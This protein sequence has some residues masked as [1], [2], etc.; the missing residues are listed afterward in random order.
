[1][2]KILFYRTE[3]EVYILKNLP[4]KSKTQFLLVK[5]LPGVGVC[6]VG[7]LVRVKP[8]LVFAALHDAG[9][10]PLLEDQRAHCVRILKLKKGI[11]NQ[12]FWNC[13]S[14]FN[15]NSSL[16]VQFNSVGGAYRKFVL[17]GLLDQVMFV[18]GVCTN[19][20]LEC[21][22]GDD[23]FGDRGKVFS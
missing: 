20:E 22:V 17:L 18:S 21:T 12:L 23:C 19:L 16:A 1:M 7:I 14:K 13:K 10:E 15:K 9:G 5:F 4:I 11:E 6:D 2:Q 8:H 3:D